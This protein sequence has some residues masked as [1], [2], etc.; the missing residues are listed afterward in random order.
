MN[1]NLYT[2]VHNNPILSIDP[3]GLWTLDCCNNLEIQTNNDAIQKTDLRP[4]VRNVYNP[5]AIAQWS[6]MKA[7]GMSWAHP[8]TGLGAKLPSLKYL[9]QE[10]ITEEQWV[11]GVQ[12]IYICHDPLF[13]P[14]KKSFRAKKGSEYWVTLSSQEIYAWV[15]WDWRDWDP[16]FNYGDPSEGDI[17]Y[18]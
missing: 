16:N 6:I 7:L 1:L 8:A 10:R 5:I 14:P 15:Y 11:H 3:F 12:T 9:V 17:I 13:W 18:F 4:R 2:Y